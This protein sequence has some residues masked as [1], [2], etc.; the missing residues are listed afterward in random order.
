MYYVI[1]TIGLVDVC[2]CVPVQV[3]QNKN[4]VMAGSCSEQEILACLSKHFKHDTF[5]SEL[6]RRAVLAVVQGECGVREQSDE[7]R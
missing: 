4:N 6:Q 1:N 3:N 5:K 7:V 2:V